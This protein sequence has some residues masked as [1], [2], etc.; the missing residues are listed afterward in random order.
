[1]KSMVLVAGTGEKSGRAAIRRSW[2]AR[3]G[4]LAGCRDDAAEEWLYK[5]PAR[6]DS[7]G[8]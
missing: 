6:N 8:I 7:R 3:K 4:R 1:M 5:R 2:L